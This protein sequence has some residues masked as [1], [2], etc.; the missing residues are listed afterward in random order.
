MNRI[1]HLGL[2]AFHRAHQ[3][4]YTADAGGDWEICGVA[5]RSRTVAD[6]LR[7]SGGRY[8]LIERGPV[9]D[10]ERQIGG[11][12]P[13]PTRSLTRSCATSSSA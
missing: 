1:V 2:G 9:E 13:S 3:A 11:T 5:W 4:V 10:C 7:T 12:R 8:R 6:A